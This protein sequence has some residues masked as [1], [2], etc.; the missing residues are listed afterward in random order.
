MAWFFH[1]RVALEQVFPWTTPFRQ[2][3]WI[4]LRSSTAIVRQGTVLRC[5][6][7]AILSQGIVQNCWCTAIL[8]QVTMLH[9]RCCT[10]VLSHGTVVWWYGLV[11]EHVMVLEEEF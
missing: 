9:K 7:T 8:W 2:A 10:A 1:W 11:V 6:C 4:L 3:G 5:G